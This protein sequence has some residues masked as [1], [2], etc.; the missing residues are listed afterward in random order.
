MS[1]WEAPE[2]RRYKGKNGSRNWLMAGLAALLVVLLILLAL[3]QCLVYSDDGSIR[4]ELPWQQ[5]ESAAD[6]DE[7]LDVI[8]KPG[9]GSETSETNA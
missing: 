5:E 8:I 9:P 3:Q 7:E 6:R 1:R 2:Y 4:V